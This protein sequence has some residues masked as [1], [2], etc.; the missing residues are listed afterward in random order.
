M[1]F[2]AFRVLSVLGVAISEDRSLSRYSCYVSKKAAVQIS[3]KDSHLISQL[4]GAR[5]RLSVDRLLC[6]YLMRIP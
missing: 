3:G 6:S 5:K 1:K 2:S 4:K